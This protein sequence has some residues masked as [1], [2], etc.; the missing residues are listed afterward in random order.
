MY[1]LGRMRQHS[2]HKELNFTEIIRCQCANTM[3]LLVYSPFHVYKLGSPLLP[4]PVRAESFFVHGCFP[5]LHQSERRTEAAPTNCRVSAAR[6]WLHQ[7]QQRDYLGDLQQ[8]WAVHVWTGWNSDTWTAAYEKASVGKAG[9]CSQYSTHSSP[10]QQQS[11]S[12]HEPGY[13]KLCH[14]LPVCHTILHT[15]Y[16]DSCHRS[17]LSKT[18]LKQNSHQGKRTLFS[19]YAWTEGKERSFLKSKTNLKEGL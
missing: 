2:I 5:S 14:A 9:L 6:H 17:Y 15:P 11:L 16:E 1:E 13:V 18:H 10:Q 3:N 8:P 7:I 12:V 4:I 19:S